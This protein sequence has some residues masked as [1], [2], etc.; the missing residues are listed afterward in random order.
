MVGVASPPR[1]A[2]PS[3]MER[4]GHCGVRGCRCTHLAPDPYFPEAAACDR[5]W[6]TA[7][8]GATTPRGNPVGPDAVVV[9]PRCRMAAERAAA[10][11]VD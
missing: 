11:V 3:A 5:G 1:G 6:T 8:P 7:P 10:G 9:C 4:I 2:G